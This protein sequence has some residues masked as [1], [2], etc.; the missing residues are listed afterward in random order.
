MGDMSF[1][2]RGLVPVVLAGVLA[3]LRP[4][5]A[6]ADATLFLGAGT[7][8]D[9]R[10]VVGGALGAGL[11]VVGFEF[12]YAATREDLAVAAPALHTFMGNVLLQTPVPVAGVQIYGTVGGGLYRERLG[13]AVR[14]TH[15]GTNVGGGVKIGLAGPLRLRLDYRVFV[16]RGTPLHDTTSRFYAGLNLAF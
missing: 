8:P 14:E 2:N 16:L 11:L 5:P 12:E 13:D 15:I 3:I 9:T 10:P 1:S 6:L 4:A 7:S